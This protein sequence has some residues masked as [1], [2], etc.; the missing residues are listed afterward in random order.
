M[1]MRFRALLGLLALVPPLALAGETRRVYRE[2]DGDAE[3]VHRFT[4]ELDGQHKVIRLES[5][6]PFGA[7]FQT[8]HVDDQLATLAWDYDAPL[9][10]TKVRAERHG[11]EISLQGVHEGDPI[12]KRFEVGDQLWNQV[13]HIGMEPFVRGDGT[14]TRFHAIGTKGRGD[15]RIARFSF[16]KLTQESRSI[17]GRE[18]ALARYQ[19]SLTGLLSVFWKGHYWYRRSDGHFVL[20]RQKGKERE[21][22]P[23]MVLIAEESAS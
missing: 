18:L 6:T 5:E 9:A 4:F 13:F 17:A 23:V 20:Y 16:K 14:A 8:Y 2:R 19:I 1:M 7:I 21:R 22:D 12:S 10:R 11:N 15:M 3:I